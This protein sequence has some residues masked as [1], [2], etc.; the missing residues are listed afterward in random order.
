MRTLLKLLVA[1]GAL[2]VLLAVADQGARRYAENRAGQQL[3]E[4]AGSSTTPTVTFAGPVFLTQVLQGRFDEVDVTIDQPSNRGQA[5]G[6][7]QV[8]VRL[9]GVSFPRRDA[10]MGRVQTATAQRVTAVGSIPYATFSRSLASVGPAAVD[11]TYAYDS[12]GRVKAAG[13]VST[14]VGA[15]SVT[16]VAGVQIID[17]R[18][19]VTP[20]P[21][22]LAMVPQALRPT[23]VDLLTLGIRL[24]G[25]PYGLTP[26]GLTVTPDGVLLQATGSGVNLGTP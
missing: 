25:L 20:L 7:E 16:A 18:L 6:V 3:Q 14:P 12:P 17:G 2:V 10:L 22:T 4:A 21:D 23:A 26:S 5:L 8:S 19:R 15:F 11:V 24:P 9:T 13:S 1:L